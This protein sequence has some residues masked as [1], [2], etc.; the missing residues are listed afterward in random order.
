MISAKPSEEGER[1]FEHPNWLEPSLRPLLC[2][3]G[4]G[5]QR[6]PSRCR[7][8]QGAWGH[9][10]SCFCLCFC[11]CDKERQQRSRQAAASV[12][13][14]AFL[15]ANKDKE[16]VVETASGLQYKILKSGKAGGKTPLVGTKCLCHYRG[17]HPKCPTNS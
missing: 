5:R 14:K 9:P 12:E 11:V 4:L 8:T 16:G 17:E 7:E 13:G 6:L 1:L 15:A 2:D 3:Q 10:P